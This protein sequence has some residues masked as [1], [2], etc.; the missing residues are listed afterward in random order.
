MP[1][2]NTVVSHS[3]LKKITLITIDG[4]SL[5]VNSKL[6]PPT[7]LNYRENGIYYID[8][9]MADLLILMLFEDTS[10]HKDTLNSARMTLSA[11]DFALKYNL[12][13][14]VREMT[15][16][17]F[18]R[19]E[20]L[21]NSKTE[22]K[23][24]ELNLFT[25]VS[26]LIMSDNKI[27][28]D[29]FKKLSRWFLKSFPEGCIDDNLNGTRLSSYGFGNGELSPSKLTVGDISPLKSFES[30]GDIGGAGLNYSSGFTVRRNLFSFNDS[31][32]P[33][34]GS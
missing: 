17:C 23:I 27:I 13:K 10:T 24:S 14:S 33:L 12:V 8:I 19:I 22:I 28:I 7:I 1:H 18:R 2:A 4:K 6:F 3:P 9:N 20:K 15:E 5:S 29:D 16:Q 21:K 26:S 32:L 30:V 31:N 34:F 25:T 11:F